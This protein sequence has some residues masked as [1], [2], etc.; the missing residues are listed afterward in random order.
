[1]RAV[2]FEQPGGPEV[3]KLMDLPV[4]TIE[5]DEVLVQV[6]ACGLNHLDLWVRGGLPTKITMPHIGGCE[7]VGVIAE[8]GKKVKG[9]AKGPAC[10]GL[11][12][13]GLRTLRLVRSK[14]R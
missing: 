7:T 9:F 4:P 13:P 6:K 11:A 5:D 14:P 3:L 8:I 12:R 2:A 10:H 1:M